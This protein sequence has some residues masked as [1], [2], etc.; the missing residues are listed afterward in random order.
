M[1]IRYFRA[2]MITC[3][4]ENYGPILRGPGEGG[5]ASSPRQKLPRKPPAGI[6]RRR[7]SPQGNYEV[8]QGSYEVFQGTQSQPAGK[9]SSAAAL[10]PAPDVCLLRP[11]L[12]RA[13]E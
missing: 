13:F 3:P 11:A 12:Y 5:G 7:E 6:G 9:I 2:G 4:E 1:T 10:G 8:F